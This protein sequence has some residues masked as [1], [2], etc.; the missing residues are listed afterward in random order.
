M[1]CACCNCV[2]QCWLNRFRCVEGRWQ[3]FGHLQSR[4]VLRC[5]LCLCGSVE[6]LLMKRGTCCRRRRCHR[7]WVPGTQG[8]TEGLPPLA[9][10]RQLP[11]L[12]A[13]ALALRAP[14]YDIL[15]NSIFLCLHVFAVVAIGIC[16]LTLY[17]RE[18]EIILFISLT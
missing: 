11:F 15:G 13:R 5:H 9:H 17:F 3:G 10:L 4:S 7:C 2:Q 14:T 12:P 18:V 6:M 1:G 16:C 8:Q